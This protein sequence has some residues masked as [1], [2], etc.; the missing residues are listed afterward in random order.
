MAIEAQKNDE[1]KEITDDFLTGLK[2]CILPNMKTREQER[3]NKK[4][5]KK[6]S[7]ETKVY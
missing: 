2:T 5:K 6:Y 1:Q 4:Q 3:Y 7:R